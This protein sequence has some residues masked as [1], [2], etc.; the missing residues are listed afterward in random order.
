MRS[1]P[2]IVSPHQVSI[3][4]NHDEA[5]YRWRSQGFT[6][7]VLLHVDAHHD[8]Y[9]SDWDQ[10][11]S[12][13]IANFVLPAV[14]EDFVREIIW[15]VPDETW[16]S[17]V[18]RNDLRRTVRR[19]RRNELLTKGISEDETSL[20]TRILGKPFRL[21][22]VN[23]IPDIREPVLLD[24]DVDFLVTPNIGYRG[25]DFFGRLPWLWPGDLLDHLARRGVEADY[26]TI[27]YSVEGGYTPLQW[28]YLG[29]EL[30]LRLQP[31]TEKNA[32]TL[33]GFDTM[34]AAAIAARQGDF[35]AA[36]KT[37]LNAKGLL[38]ELAA[39]DLHLAHLHTANGELQ[40]A[41]KNYV[42]AVKLDQ[43]YSTPFNSTGIAQFRLRRWKGSQQA[44]QRALAWDA[45]DPYAH[46]GLGL[47]SLRAKA[48]KAAQG[49][50][51]GTLRKNAS[52][53]DA[54]RGLAM[55]LERQGDIQGAIYVLE[56]SLQSALLGHEAIMDELISSD[57]DHGPLDLGHGSTHADLARLYAKLGDVTV[58]MAG[59]EM[60]I[61]AGDDR[62]RTQLAVARLLFRAGDRREALAALRAGLRGIPRG[63]RRQ[64]HQMAYD[65]R[66]FIAQEPHRRW[67]RTTNIETTMWL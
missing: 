30:A 20:S 24:V 53:I 31:R 8:M 13:N 25:H 9:G 11:D 39:P 12:I 22:S 6:Q 63:L 56:R 15:V 18:G 55:A 2:L 48:W 50:F 26:V 52:S 17:R 38:P 42:N 10:P 46:L 23:H 67:F 29:D 45:D 43:S 37:Y 66:R 41:R 57:H 16:I 65:Y 19:L 7:R 4:E 40:S 5:Y 1:N 64:W 33:Q 47:L 14:A 62:V 34:R 3:F 35:A 60:A 58:A 36:E 49:H 28:K 61:A 44:H 51:E 21:C 27:A 59:Y 54:L 32:A